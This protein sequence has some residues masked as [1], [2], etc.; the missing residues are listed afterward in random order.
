MSQI[1]HRLPIKTCESLSTLLAFIDDRVNVIARE[2]FHGNMHRI[3]P[4]QSQPAPSIDTGYNKYMIKFQ[5]P[6]YVF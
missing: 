4:E 3:F 1:C 6:F 2:S 5:I